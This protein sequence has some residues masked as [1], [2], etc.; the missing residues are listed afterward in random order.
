MY[1]V[2]IVDDEPFILEGLKSLINWEEYGLEIAAQALNGIEAVDV[3]ESLSINILITDIKMPKMNGLELIKYV[4]NKSLNI[5]CIVLSGYDD[6][7]FVKEAA[8]LGIENYLLKPVDINELIPTLMNSIKNIENEFN[9]ISTMEQGISILRDN[10]LLRWVTNDINEN[11]LLQKAPLLNI[12]L[13]KRGFVVSIVKI[14][15]SV[16]SDSTVIQDT[17]LLRSSVCNICRHITS[18]NA[19]TEIFYDSNGYIVLLFSNVNSGK[20]NLAFDDI[21]GSCI[22]AIQINLNAKVFIAVGDFVSEYQNVH[23][24]YIHANELLDYSLILNPNRIIFYDENKLK[25]VENKQRRFHIDSN[26]LHVL[27]ATK[28]KPGCLE[29]IEDIY[30]QVNENGSLTPTSIQNITIELLFNIISTVKSL[31]SNADILFDKFK[32]PFINVLNLK[33]LIEIIEWQKSFVCAA[34]DFLCSED[35]RLSP[36]IKKVLNYVESN[37]NQDLNLKIISSKFNINPIYLGQLFIKEIG[38]P[39]T[40]YINKIRVEK[41]KHLLLHTNLKAI[42]ISEEVGYVNP[43]YF[44]TIFKKITGLSP[45]EFKGE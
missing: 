4:K 8:K 42:E 33:T 19:S 14:I 45:S 24:S 26:A 23:H 7:E 31:N 25:A 11:E 5:K 40:N 44:Y 35:E 22:S 21:L 2:L 36:I 17:N 18:K 16:S 41:A 6:F 30:S 34:I 1:K 15:Q 37:Y 27:L 32:D 28:N 12:D 39:F 3:L 13:I 20:D 38:E 29:L 10:I 9:K 43:N